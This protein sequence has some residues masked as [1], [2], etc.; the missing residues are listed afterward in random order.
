MKATERKS[1]NPTL[2]KLRGTPFKTASELKS[3][4]EKILRQEWESV[5]RARVRRELLH[6]E[7]NKKILAPFLNGFKVNFVGTKGAN[8]NLV[9]VHMAADESVHVDIDQQLRSKDTNGTMESL[10]KSLIHGFLGGYLTALGLKADEPAF[11]E[12]LDKTLN[13]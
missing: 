8:E 5:E 7:E 10:V 13:S 4:E 12:S 1:K 3:V 11:Q 6:K 9:K 2:I